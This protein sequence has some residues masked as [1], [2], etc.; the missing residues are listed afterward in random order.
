MQ[1]ITFFLILILWISS[2]GVTTTL[3]MESKRVTALV[4]ARG[5]SKGIPF[6]NLAEVGGM[7]LLGRTITVAKEVNVFD[8]VWV[9]TDHEKI[10]KE[11]SKC[12]L[13][14]PAPL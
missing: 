2:E 8:E 4:L 6:K 11:A 14:D 5:G 13:P 1:I 10:A 7:S 9:S 12:K 3:T